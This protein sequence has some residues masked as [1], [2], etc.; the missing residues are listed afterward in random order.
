MENEEEK[1]LGRRRIW[2]GWERHKQAQ[3]EPPSNQQK[4]YFLRSA[5]GSERDLSALVQRFGLRSG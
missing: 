3:W 1:D 2:A 4:P 5:T